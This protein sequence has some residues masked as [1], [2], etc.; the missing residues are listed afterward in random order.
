VRQTIFETELIS[1]NHTTNSDVGSIVMNHVTKFRV[2]T[3]SAYAIELLSFQVG[4][5]LLSIARDCL[6]DDVLT[7]KSTFNVSNKQD[8]TRLLVHHFG[9]KDYSLL[10]PQ[11]DDVDLKARLGLFYEEAEKTYEQSAWLSF[12]LAAGAV[13]EGLLFAHQKQPNKKFEDLINDKQQNLLTETE[14]A[15]AHLLRNHRNLVH[16]NRYTKPFVSRSDALEGYVLMTTLVK[17]GW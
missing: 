12:S 7:V 1:S 5:L 14:K 17:R 9:I 2:R 15:L 4:G 8:Q 6:N 13:I 10:F 11:I 3:A 16:A